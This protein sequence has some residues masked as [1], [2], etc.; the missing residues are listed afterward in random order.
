MGLS[1]TMWFPNVADWGRHY[2]L[3]AVDTLGSAGKSI[4]VKPLKSR[5]D[6]AGWLHD[7]LDG[8]GITQ[9]HLL[10]HSHGGWLALSL[11]L[12]PVE[13]VRRLILLAPAASFLRLVPQFYLRG[14]PTI[15]FPRR[16]WITR[17]MQWMTVEGFIVNELFV[18]QFVLG[19]KHFRSQI[20]VLPTVFTDDELRRIQVPTLLL[21]GEEEVI[22]DPQAAVN[23]ARRLMPHLEAEMIPNA[24]HGL[25]MEQA[26]FVDERVLD[27][28]NQER[29]VV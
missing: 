12:H 20:T 8:L 10:G 9:T 11:A 23:R 26:E 1:A 3:Y 6:C 4:A 2:R 17:F 25:P 5:A 16:S 19:M 18:E 21:I 15:L 14:I 13:R 22:Y 27:F 24:S 28:L 7:V 29:E